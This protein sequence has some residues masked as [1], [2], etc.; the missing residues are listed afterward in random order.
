[1]FFPWRRNQR[2]LRGDAE[3]PFNSVPAFLD[4]ETDPLLKREVCFSVTYYSSPGWYKREG[5]TRCF[6]LI[7]SQIPSFAFSSLPPSFHTL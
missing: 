5:E 2:D 7:F 1:M 3:D 4:R 6:S